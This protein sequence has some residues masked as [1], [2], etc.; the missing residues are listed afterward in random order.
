[1]LFVDKKTGDVLTDVEIRL[2]HSNVSFPI[3]LTSDIIESF[4]YEPVFDGPK[5]KTS[6]PYQTIEKDKV[7]KVEGKWYVNYVV[8]PVFKEY[9]DSEGVLHTVE[10]Q[11]LNHKLN[12]DNREASSVR[13]IRNNLLSESDWTQ[14]NNSPL[15]E[16]KKNSWRSY[17][18]CLRD[19]S[20]QVGFPWKINWP[21]KPGDS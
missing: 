18:Q 17:R 20:S 3:N 21:L 14:L 4:G 7:L 11:K 12:I 9:T 8:G 16:D 19:I 13:K 6:G 2:I 1:M 10:Q 5:P 15:E